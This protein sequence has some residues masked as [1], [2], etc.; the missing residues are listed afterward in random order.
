[1]NLKY[2]TVYIHTSDL[3]K[4]KTCGEINLQILAPDWLSEMR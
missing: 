3:L 4:I 1:V 2:T